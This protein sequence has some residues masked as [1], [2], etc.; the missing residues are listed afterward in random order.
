MAALVSGISGAVVAAAVPV[1]A[2]AR[3][4]IRALT[5]T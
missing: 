1:G 5:L 4:T 3:P 2:W